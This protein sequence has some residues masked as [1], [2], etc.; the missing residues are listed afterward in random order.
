[1]AWRGGQLAS[2]LVLSRMLDETYPVEVRR[3]ITLL[4]AARTCANGCYRFAPPFLAAIARGVGVS[5]N[6]IGVALAIAELAGLLSPLTARWV[7]HLHRRTAMTAGLLGVGAGTLLAATSQGLVW[8]ATALVVLSQS[9]V[10]FDLGLGSWIAD[11]VAY[12]RRSRVVGLTETSWAL[13]LL[14]GVSVMGLVTAAA[15]WRAGYLTGAVAVITLAVV[16]RR[17]LPDDPDDPGSTGLGDPDD[18]DSTG[19]GI[20]PSGTGPGT[21]AV[22]VARPHRAAPT[23]AAVGLEGWIVVAGAVGLMGASQSLFVTFGSWL[24]DNFAFS[25]AG[26]AVVVFGIGLGELLASIT[27]ARRT[28]AWGKEWSVAMGALMMV[29]ASAGLALWND[30]LA[31]GLAFLAV[32]I[33]GFE[34]AIVSALAIGSQLVAGSPARG[35]ALMIGGGTLGRAVAAVIATHAYD[36]YGIGWPAVMCAVG[37]AI[38]AALMLTAR[39]LN[40]HPSP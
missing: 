17:C 29:P 12:D 4:T 19:L 34:F 2:K 23:G 10:M 3:H 21:L 37:A 40:H 26:I 33:A 25:A 28:D 22:P 9:K 13:G 18:P 39:H 1:M 27:S 31:V 24:E 15:G 16:V 30:H 20:V 35:L 36:R 32:A 11:H 7:D 38:A 14:V 8:F 6:D 5:L